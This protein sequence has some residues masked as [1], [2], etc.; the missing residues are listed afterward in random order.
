MSGLEDGDDISAGL[1]CPYCSR[2]FQNADA[3]RGHVS[4]AHKLPGH[5]KKHQLRAAHQQSHLNS[6]DLERVE[7]GIDQSPSKKA[8]QEGEDRERSS[9]N[10]LQQV[11]LD[12]LMGMHQKM[13]PYQVQFVK[14]QVVKINET[15]SK[16][17]SSALQAVLHEHNV[18]DDSLLQAVMEVAERQMQT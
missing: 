18:T 17:L 4:H 12:A 5:S 11:E 7:S 10:G 1:S 6:L 2:V 3:T 9:A 15:R 13:A 16:F 14:G 8:K